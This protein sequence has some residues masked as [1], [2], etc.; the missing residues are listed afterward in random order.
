VA[1]QKYKTRTEETGVEGRPMK[2]AGQLEI[3]WDSMSTKWG[4][5]CSYMKWI[6]NYFMSQ[7]PC[8][9]QPPS[10]FLSHIFLPPP[11]THTHVCSL[12]V[13]LWFACSHRTYHFSTVEWSS[14][15]SWVDRLLSTLVDL[16]LDAQNCCLFTY[17]T[18]IKILYM[19]RALPCSSSDIPIQ[20]DQ[21]KIV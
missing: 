17:N 12:L 3:L 13:C 4:F 15:S 10:L 8:R 19:F 5:L 6:R 7:H 20:K 1:L 11:P 16:Q 18:F 2:R 21:N 14:R 9:N